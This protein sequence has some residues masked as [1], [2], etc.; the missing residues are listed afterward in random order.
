MNTRREVTELYADMAAWSRFRAEKAAAESQWRKADPLVAE[1]ADELPAL[2]TVPESD[3]FSVA[4]WLTSLGS[5]RTRRSYIADMLTWR[6]WLAEREQHV[7]IAGH[8][9]V[10]LWVREQISSGAAD[11]SVRRRLA[12]ISSFY[13]YLLAE[14]LVAANP[15]IGVQ[16][17]HSEPDA[18]RIKLTRE[19]CRALITAADA[20]TGRARLRTR[21]IV[22]LLLLNTMRVDE[23]LGANIG[24]LG[25]DCGHRVLGI[26]GTGTRRTKIALTPGTFAALDT[27]LTS[28]T[29]PWRSPPGPVSRQPLLATE[30]GER[31]RQS[32]LWELVRRL[33]KAA[34]I[35]EW[36]QISPHSLRHTEITTALNS[37]MPLPDV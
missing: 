36:D 14:G 31:L 34:G 13:R 12:G 35:A 5:A 27:Y 1:V 17:P 6:A 16:R 25:T 19:Q 18:S 4:A 37:G 22:R 3:Q 28:R 7:L 21:V 20:D 23:V 15:T 9:D 11:S 32:Q 24:D 30:Y 26:S 29:P 33:A 2:L 8:A 10:D